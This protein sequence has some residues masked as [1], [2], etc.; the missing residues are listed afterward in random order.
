MIRVLVMEFGVRWLCGFLRR[1]GIIRSPSHIL[2]QLFISA[3]IFFAGVCSS[4]DPGPPERWMKKIRDFS[5][6]A[7]SESDVVLPTHTN[8]WA[9][10]LGIVGDEESLALEAE[11]IASKYGL[12]NMGKVSFSTIQFSAFFKNACYSY[13]F[14]LAKQ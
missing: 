9:V 13:F 2:S 7:S 6:S 3:L 14:K 8:S 5:S 12:I 10:Q 1:G 4:S 11:Q